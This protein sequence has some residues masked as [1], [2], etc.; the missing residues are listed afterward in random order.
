MA[1][2]KKRNNCML[3]LVPHSPNIPSQHEEPWGGLG[4]AAP[5][6]SHYTTMCQAIWPQCSIL[7]H[8]L[9]LESYQNPHR[10]VQK[11]VTSLGKQA[12]GEAYP[13]PFHPHRAVLI[14]FSEPRFVGNIFL[15]CFL[16]P[17]RC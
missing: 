14:S 1:M 12:W 4:G 11:L 9:V 2:K 17:G 13:S 3:T 6:P 16:P 7:G 8:C 10:L 15:G 5:S